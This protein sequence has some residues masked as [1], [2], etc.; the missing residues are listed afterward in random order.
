MDSFAGKPDGG[1]SNHAARRLDR[2]LP[3]AALFE[4]SA[5]G[6]LMQKCRDPGDWP[7]LS[8]RAA[9]LFHMSRVSQLERDLSHSFG[10]SLFFCMSDKP[11]Q[12]G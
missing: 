10:A 6:V 7:V 3:V 9:I 2:R 12:A 8:S 5:A 1:V 4:T 11:V